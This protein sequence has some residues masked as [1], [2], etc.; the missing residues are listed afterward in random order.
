[1]VSEKVTL[2]TQVTTFSE[3]Y[4]REMLIREKCK[5]SHFRHLRHWLAYTSGKD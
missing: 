1:M 2:V 5:R 3:S 4:Y